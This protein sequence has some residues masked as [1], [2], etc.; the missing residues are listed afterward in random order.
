MIRKDFRAIAAVLADHK[1]EPKTID[2]LVTAFADVC[3][4]SSPY[5]D[6]DKF[7]KAIYQKA[8]RSSH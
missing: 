1:E 5:F 4:Q 2:E 3:E 8:E 6:R 7:F